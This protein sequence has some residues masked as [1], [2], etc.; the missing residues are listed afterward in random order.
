MQAISLFM[1]SSLLISGFA[2]AGDNTTW[3]AQSTDSQYGKVINSTKTESVQLAA[4][5]STDSDSTTAQQQSRHSA[6]MLLARPYSANFNH[7]FWIY[8]AWITLHQDRD[9]DGYYH[10]FTLEFDADTEYDMAE[11][12]ARIYLGTNEVF[13]QYHS[14]ANFFIS[15]D[16]TD[17]A[18]VVETELLSG[19]VP[20]D[21]EVMIELYNAYTDEL[22]AVYDG[23]NDADLYLVSLE[24]KNYDRAQQVVVVHEHGGSLGWWALLLL[25]IVFWR[26]VNSQLKKQ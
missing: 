18:F 4:K 11:V 17:D 25:P 22:V 23:Y 16:S 10:E 26:K 2:Y 21:Y 13:K 20:N 3:S 9:S 5:S 15:G 24:S 7:E 12:Y 19:F 6:S 14:T 8:D 1:A